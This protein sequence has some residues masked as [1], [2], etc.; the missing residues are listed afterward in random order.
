MLKQKRLP[1]VAHV[2]VCTNDRGGERK[3]CVDNNSKLIKPNL[4]KAVNEKG[5]KWKVRTSTSGC[6]GVCAKGSNVIIYPHEVLHKILFKQTRVAPFR[7][8][9]KFKKSLTQIFDWYIVISFI[10]VYFFLSCLNRSTLFFS[11][12]FRL[13]LL[14]LF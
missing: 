4:K 9:M 3:S 2:F 7:P 6:M 14:I 13:F 1:Y 10:S 11:F 12:D 5:W 8:V